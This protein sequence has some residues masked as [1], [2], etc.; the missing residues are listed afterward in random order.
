MATTSTDYYETLSVARDADADAIKKSY[1]KLAREYH[2]DVNHEPGAEARF[3]EIQSAYE[4]LSDP[5]KRSR[6]DRFGAEGVG[7]AAGGGDPFGGMGGDIFDFINMGFGGGAARRPGSPERG[8]DVRYD[9]S[10]TLEEAYKGGEKTVTLPKVET[11]GTCKGNGAEPG[12]KPETCSQCQGAGQVRRIQNIP[13]LGR[14]QTMAP[15]D[16]CGGEGKTVKTPC[17]TCAGRGRVRAE[18]PVTIP[19]PVGIADGMQMPLTGEGNAGA[20]SG[21]AGDLYVFF[22]VAEHPLFERDGA[23]LYTEVPLTFTQAALGDTVPVP[24]ISGDAQTVTVP[25]GTQ[26]GTVFR[27][28][29]QGMPDIR[30]RTNAKGDLHVTVSVQTPKKLSDAERKLLQ[31]LA[32]LRGEKSGEIAPVVEEHQG[33]FDKL[34]NIFTGH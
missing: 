21:G 25:E 11:C 20:N 30:S 17:H 16:K 34:K 8:A 7:G 14:V 23:D 3:K 12:T 32:V 19:I 24:T 22:S 33:V 31:D 26:S 29:K 1:R 28:P 15:C 18:R 6:Y 5:E 10:V 4:V 13:L 2:P 9:L 27:V